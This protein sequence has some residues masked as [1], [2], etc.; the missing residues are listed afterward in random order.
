M[1]RIAHKITSGKGSLQGGKT[2][3][4]KEIREVL[5]AKEMAKLVEN[6]S[7]VQ[8][9]VDASPVDDD[10]ISVDEMAVLDELKVLTV[11]EL[12]KLCEFLGLEGYASLNKPDLIKLIEAARNP[13]ETDVDLDELGLDAL[14]ALATEEEIEFDDD[15]DEEA[16]RDIIA[17]AMEA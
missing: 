14:K 16:L 7:I 4:E 6:G 13:E 10:K 1:Y 3:D 15:A 17:E 8:I 12:K 2:V 5:T 11:P 9:V